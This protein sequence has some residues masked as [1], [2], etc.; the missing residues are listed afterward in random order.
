M[1]RSDLRR[2]LLSGTS[3]AISSFKQCTAFLKCV[4][5]GCSLSISC[6]LSISSCRFG[7]RFLIN[8]NLSIPDLKLVL[9]DCVLCLSIACDGM[10]KSQTKV[11][12]I[13]LEFLLHSEGF[14]L[15]L[16]FSFKG[17]LH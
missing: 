1:V 8:L 6:N 2:F 3:L 4:L 12:S 17:S 14:C 11:S 16:S 13:S 5:H 10:L 15:A 9:L 7:S